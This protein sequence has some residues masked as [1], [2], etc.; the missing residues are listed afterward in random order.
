[1]IRFTRFTLRMALILAHDLAVTALA[2]VAAFYIRFED[3]GLAER[4]PLLVFVLPAFVAYSGVVFTVFGLFK[5]KWRFT[6]LPDLMTIVKV[7]SVLAVVK[8]HS[9]LAS[10]HTAEAISGAVPSLSIGILERI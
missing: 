9:S 10:Q 8:E 6:S 1:M 2:V 3:A 4:W 5:T 7:S